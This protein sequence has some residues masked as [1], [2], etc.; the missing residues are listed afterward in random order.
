MS[1]IKKALIKCDDGVR[2]SIARWETPQHG[3]TTELDHPMELQADRTE[4]AQTGPPEVAAPLYTAPLLRGAVRSAPLQEIAKTVSRALACLTD[5]LIWPYCLPL[6]AEKSVELH[7]EID[8][9]HEGYIRCAE[10]NAANLIL[11]G[12]HNHLARLLG[13][14]LLEARDHPPRILGCDFRVTNEVY[15]AQDWL[16]TRGI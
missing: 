2:S 6:M 4:I 7:E 11:S 12:L 3:R 16:A 1:K 14:S 15:S 10:R 9:A 13:N 5:R 8:G